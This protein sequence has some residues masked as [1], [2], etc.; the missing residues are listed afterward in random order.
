MIGFNS[1]RWN[2]IGKGSLWK[3][4]TYSEITLKGETP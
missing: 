4:R 3:G 2:K 1:W